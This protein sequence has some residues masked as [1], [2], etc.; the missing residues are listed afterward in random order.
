MIAHRLPWVASGLLVV[1]LAGLLL[2]GSGARAQDKKDKDKLDLDKIPKA[3]MDALKAKFPKAE[4]RKWT[5]E[6]EGDDIVYDI[7]FSQAGRKYE[8]DIKENGTYI[9]YEKEIAAKDLPKAV[10]KAVDTRYPKATLKEVMEITAVMGK[11]EK[12]EGY[13]I[14]LTTS[15]KREVEVT[16]APDGKILEDSGA[17]KD[18]KK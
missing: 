14:V 11:A 15:D 7:E 16:V 5:K 10:R 2:V 3:V 4:I 18:E 17:K 13:E 1:V 8:A 9:N 12:L 6:K